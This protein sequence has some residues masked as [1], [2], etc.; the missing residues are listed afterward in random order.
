MMMSLLTGAATDGDMYQITVRA[1][2]KTT[3]GDD[4]RALST[5]THVTVEVTDVN[6]SG[7]VTLNRLQPEVGTAIMAS[8]SD[9]TTRLRPSGDFLM[10]TTQLPSVGRG[11]SPRSP[12]PSLTL[13]T[14]G[15]MPPG[16]T[17]PTADTYTPHGD[18]V[19]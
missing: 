19:E 10:T 3:S 4:H 9:P 18:C 17:V 6:E 12:I 16:K 11:T 5:E 15:L 7:S 13:T 8:L 2:E 1:T 14:I